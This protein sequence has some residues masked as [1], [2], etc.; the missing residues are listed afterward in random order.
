VF[1]QELGKIL[2]N[3]LSGVLGKEIEERWYKREGVIQNPN[4]KYSIRHKIQH[5]M[6]ILQEKCT[7]IQIQK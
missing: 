2:F 5:I 6:E 7:H 1:D 4:A 3:K